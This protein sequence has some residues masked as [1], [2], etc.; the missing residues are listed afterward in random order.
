MLPLSKRIRSI[1]V[2]GPNADD[3][4]NQ[5]GDYTSRVVL[6]DIVTVL[7]GIRNRIG[8]NAKISYVKGCNVKGDELDEIEKAV[9]AAKKAG[10]AVLVLGENEW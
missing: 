1:A 9:D 3:E 10:I 7:D 8:E 5:L 4:K 6:Q 2:I